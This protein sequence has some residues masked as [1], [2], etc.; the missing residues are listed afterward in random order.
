[1]VTDRSSQ[2]EKYWLLLLRDGT[3]VIHVPTSMV[4][5]IKKAIIK[6]KSNHRWRTGTVFNPLKITVTEAKDASGK[7]IANKT[8]LSF[9]MHNLQ[10]KDI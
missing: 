7:V 5:G 10:V 9:F 6:R 1:M 3:L 8:Q 4:A 2:Y